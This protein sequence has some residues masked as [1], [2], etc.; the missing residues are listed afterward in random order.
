MGI[1]ASVYTERKD[2][3]THTM[4]VIKGDEFGGNTTVYAKEPAVDKG[5]DW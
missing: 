1:L 5:S 4:K 3:V 2:M